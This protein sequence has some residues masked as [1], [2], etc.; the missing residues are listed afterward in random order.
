M[1]LFFH[2]RQTLQKVKKNKK[3]LLSK[4]PRNAHKVEA[5][6]RSSVAPSSNI[7]FLLAF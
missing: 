2:R 6:S 7:H 1:V 3:K 5:L 4:K